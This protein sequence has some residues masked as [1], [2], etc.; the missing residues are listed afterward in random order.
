MLLSLRV[1]SLGLASAESQG[2]EC[3]V[4]WSRVRSRRKM[5][6]GAVLQMPLPPYIFI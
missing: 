6:V 2:R 1:R 3:G 5:L 4:S